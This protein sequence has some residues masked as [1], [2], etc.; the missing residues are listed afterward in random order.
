[1]K[2]NIFVVPKES[3]FWDRDKTT[4]VSMYMY[5]Y[6]LAMFYDTFLN[7]TVLGRGVFATKPFRREDFLLVYFGKDVEPR[8]GAYC[9]EFR[10]KS[11][12]FW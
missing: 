3:Y 11:K 5:M 12:T 10:W 9:F 4:F 8:D 1:M 2:T 7:A 6:V